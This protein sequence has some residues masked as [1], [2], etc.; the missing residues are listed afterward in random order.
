MTLAHN[1]PVK[2][3]SVWQR[4]KAWLTRVDEALHF[5]PLEQLQRDFVELS[6][7]IKRLEQQRK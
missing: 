5:D 4:T 2:S 6:D 1:R 3:Q 7:R